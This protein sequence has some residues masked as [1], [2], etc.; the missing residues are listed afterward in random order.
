MFKFKALGGTFL[1]WGARVTKGRWALQS[2]R[3]SKTE[4]M[5]KSESSQSQPRPGSAAAPQRPPLRRSSPGLLP[6]RD[7][8]FTHIS[9]AEVQDEYIQHEH[10][11]Q[12]SLGSDAVLPAQPSPGNSEADQ[13]IG[14]GLERHTVSMNDDGQNS[15]VSREAELM[16]L[17]GKINDVTSQRVR[18]R[19]SRMAL[20]Y[21]REDELELRVQFMRHLNSFFANID[22]PEAERLLAEYERLQ[23]ATDEYLTMENIYNHE[24][25][26]LEEQE[27]RLSLS[28]GSFSA[29]SNMGSTPHFPSYSGPWSPDPDEDRASTIAELPRC[30]VTYLARIGDERMLQERLEEL[31]SEWFITMDRKAQRNRV[32]MPLDEDSEEFLA[33]FDEE[34]AKIWKDL[35]NAQMDVI[36]LRSICL[37]QHH[38]GFDYEDLCT[39]HPFRYVGQPTAELELD[40]LSLPPRQQSVFLDDTKSTDDD[41]E[42]PE[43]DW[44]TPIPSPRRRLHFFHLLNTTPSIR[45]NEFINKWMLHQLRV[46]ILGIW[47]LHRSPLW[48]PL[49]Q[50]GWQ[51]HD[52]SHFILEAWFHDDAARA[53]LI[54][55]PS[56]DEYDTAAGHADGQE[57]RERLRSTSLPSSVFSSQ[58]ISMG[59]FVLRRHKSKT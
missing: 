18:A 39:L 6:R 33:T 19:Q 34:R 29:S 47:H 53:P 17:Y 5:V 50:Q 26:E 13:E 21:K 28:V 57:T 32:Q 37:D 55:D 51:D 16:S 9:A 7:S 24:E 1:D 59:K 36:S 46:S 40:P 30:V 49:R 11:T 58:H 31:D 3:S 20:K 44:D 8:A 54:H 12:Q 42:P 2:H 45:S 25:D 52:I 27:Y 10:G 43:L 41:S 38:S 15:K 35:N 23:A 22:H 48:Q 14:Q 56:L 4:S